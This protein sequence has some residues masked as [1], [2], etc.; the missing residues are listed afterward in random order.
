MKPLRAWLR[1]ARE[2]FDNGADIWGHRDIRFAVYPHNLANVD[3]YGTQATM[4]FGD[5]RATRRWFDKRFKLEMSA[6]DIVRAEIAWE[7]RSRL[8]MPCK[9]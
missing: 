1:N 2:D 8:E 4:L 3:F 9:S 6:I 7:N 5:L